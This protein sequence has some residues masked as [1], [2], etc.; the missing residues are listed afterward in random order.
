M[1]LSNAVVVHVM[2]GLTCILR[3][4]SIQ[5]P[6]LRAA[7]K[8]TVA[9]DASDDDNFPENTHRTWSRE[10]DASLWKIR[11]LCVDDIAKKL[12][13]GKRGVMIRIEKLCD[14]TSSAYERLFSTSPSTTRPDVNV[15]SLRT[16]KECLQRIVWDPSLDSSFFKIGYTDRI[17][18]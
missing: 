12:E 14:P 16:A 10:D 4:S 2:I 5:A 6:L 13:R 8:R 17:E 3:T 1:P 11:G 15:S 7:F 18:V 9:I